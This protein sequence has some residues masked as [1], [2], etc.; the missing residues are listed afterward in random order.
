MPLGGVCPFVC[1]FLRSSLRWS[2]TLTNAADDYVMTLRRW[3]GSSLRRSNAAFQ[4]SVGRQ[5]RRHFLPRR[6]HC[7]TGTSSTVDRVR[8][9]ARR[10]YGR[11]NRS[12]GASFNH[13]QSRTATVPSLR[14]GYRGDRSDYSHPLPQREKNY[15]N[16]NTVYFTKQKFI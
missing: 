1:P 12:H 14:S 15:V 4:L 6:G 11:H 2:L 9:P 7:W 16:K 13:R 3:V 8:C 10:R 5:T